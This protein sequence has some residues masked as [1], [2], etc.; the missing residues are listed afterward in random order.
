MTNQT[1]TA[2]QATANLA[3]Q[4]SGQGKVQATQEAVN[5]SIRRYALASQH[6]EAGLVWSV[7]GVWSA[8]LI[9][10]APVLMTGPE[11]DAFH[12]KHSNAQVVDVLVYREAC[13]A[14]NAGFNSVIT[15]HD[16]RS[17]P[18][19]REAARAAGIKSLVLAGFPANALEIGK[20]L[21]SPRF[22]A[23]P[24]DEG[25]DQWGV[26]DTTLDKCWSGD[27]WQQPDSG[28]ASVL[29]HEESLQKVNQLEQELLGKVGQLSKYVADYEC[30]VLASRGAINDVSFDQKRLVASKNAL[31]SGCVLGVAECL[32]WW[33]EAIA[34]GLLVQGNGNV[35]N[36]IEQAH[37]V[38]YVIRSLSESDVDLDGDAGAFWS[39]EDGW[40][41]LQSATLFSTTERMSMNLPMSAKL[42]AEWMLQEEARDLCAKANVSEAAEE[43]APMFVS[44]DGGKTFLP[45]TSGVRIIY[46]NV[47]VPGEDEPGE[48]H[49]NATS[50]GVI[51][52]LWV[53]R[54]EHLDHNL[55]TS[56]ELV[57]D[58]I[59]RL[60]DD[61]VLDH[62]DSPSPGM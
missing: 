39:N 4:I 37:Q 29:T 31:A 13:D 23:F 38:R 42:D 15:D 11:V 28:W 2:A 18:E 12:K 46:K 43:S 6:T 61:P 47:P 14:Y 1:N 25:N 56:S 50:E 41:S 9:D 54:E 60:V 44:L 58:M 40:G 19:S 30:G 52:D 16:Q 57:D 59:E 24:M 55:G 62:D 17:T 20:V 27:G 33:T 45:A 51:S 26:R 35:V 48:L 10:Q 3:T 34:S 7:G 22:Q 21:N 53:S 36:C 49:L 5:N 32:S 8:S